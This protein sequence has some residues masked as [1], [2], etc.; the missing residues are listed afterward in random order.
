MNSALLMYV[1]LGGLAILLPSALVLWLH[2]R[3][4]RP[5]D[6]I[7][8]RFRRL[9]RLAQIVLLLFVVN[10]IVYGSTKAPTNG[11][12]GAG[13]GT[14]APPPM[15]AMGR[16]RPLPGPAITSEDIARGWMLCESRTNEDAACYVLP[17]DA[18][19]V[20]NW[21]VRG[22]FEDVVKI[23]NG[24]REAGSGGWSFPFGGVRFD[25]L[26]AFSWGKVRF[27][28][29]DTNELVAVGA[30]M[31]AIPHRSRLWSAATTNDS[32]LVTWEDFALG[33]DTNALLSA[34]IEFFP[35]GLFIVRSNALE[36]VRRSI[37]PDDWDGDGYLNVGDDLDPCVWNPGGDSYY[38][39]HQ[40]LPS[41]CNTDVYYTVSVRISGKRSADVVFTGD[42]PSDLSDPSFRAKPGEAYDVWLLIG[43][44]Y[45]VTSSA[46][47]EVVGTSDREV[48]VEEAGENAYSIVWPVRIE[49]EP[50]FGPLLL[51][52][53]ASSDGSRSF[54]LWVVPDWL[55]GVFT[56]SSNNCCSV[57]ENGG[58]FDF[59]CG[60]NCACGGCELSGRYT[61]AGYSL[62]FGGVHC[63]C[64]YESHG[65]T[66][67]GLSV[68]DVVFKDGAL[69]S[70]SIEFH[71]GDEND[72][73]R[74]SLVLTQLSGQ[75]LIR[76]WLDADRTIPAE[77]L[78][79][80]VSSFD[81]CTLYLEG[82]ESSDV[83]EDIRFRLSWNKPDGR[84]SH[85]FEETTCAEVEFVHVGDQHFTGQE[86]HAF[87]VTNSPSPDQHA[88]VLFKDVVNTNDF[89]V[90]DFDVD[91]TLQVKPSGAPVGR[92][93]W[94]PL[95]PTPGSAVLVPTGD[96]TGRLANPKEGGVY[97]IG[98]AFDGSPTNE[99]NI[100]L[101]L[102]GASVDAVLAADFA[103]ADTFVTNMIAGFAPADLSHPLLG[104]ILFI[105]LRNGNY[106]GRPD[107]PL[108]PTV[109]AYNQ[110]NDSN[111][112]GAV[113]TLADLPI[114]VAKLSNLITGYV[115]EKMGVVREAQEFSQFIGS[116]NDLAARLSWSY[117]ND[118][119]HGT[120]YQYA[121]SNLVRQCWLGRDSK[122]IYLWPNP[123]GT[124]NHDLGPCDEDWNHRF[125]SPGFLK[126]RVP[127]RQ[128]EY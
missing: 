64:R 6:G 128:T 92:A 125:Y 60:A 42:G 84:S 45:A 23:G 30:P 29:E 78:S 46:P 71:H 1:A 51:G 116:D 87:C 100:V 88:P 104:A 11:V 68:P 47:V 4:I 106:Q 99:C 124:A 107:N 5:L 108:Q 105:S 33:R 28:L 50:D 12:D 73:E 117:G 53:G 95:P 98:A 72:R 91:M 63:G 26:W 113:A 25:S 70:M 22:A 18:T 56:W 65:L 110:V 115:C 127:P 119:A 120:N 27:A 94:F 85:V 44:T 16:P 81:A 74:G 83:V 112:K 15:L 55:D 69:Q 9:P 49:D 41:G 17:A 36:S 48:L 126:L 96:R 52:A 58:P 54:S 79:W 111:G 19:L 59:T 2:E 103:R 61:Y 43:K 35:D 37:D 66:T 13:G 122:T 7:L 118:I 93:S 102:A 82:L 86:P 97:H 121:V 67:F 21:W 34:Q 109:W 89:S 101:P 40:E 3:G 80:N 31:A 77:D 76:I 123:S 10:L 62:D 20:T 90:N 32:F 57:T 75:D 14:N 24:E 8:R 114:R 38:G 39:P